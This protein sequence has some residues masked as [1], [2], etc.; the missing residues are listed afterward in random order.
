MPRSEQRL[1][2]IRDTLQERF[3]VEVELLTHVSV[4]RSQRSWNQHVSDGRVV[5]DR[6]DQWPSVRAN[7]ERARRAALK[8]V[9]L[10]AS[11]RV[12]VKWLGE[13][14]ELEDKIERA[15]RISLRILRAFATLSCDP[16]RA[17][18]LA[19]QPSIDDCAT[20]RIFV[21]R[22]AGFSAATPSDPSGRRHTIARLPRKA[23]KTLRQQ[24]PK[25]MTLKTLARVGITRSVIVYRMQREQVLKRGTPVPGVTVQLLNEGDI[26][27]YLS[28]NLIP[29]KR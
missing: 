7:P 14:Y 18:M 28:F 20:R 10:T 6:D 5:V 2:A 27:A 9:D 17:S 23:I 25:A 19:A 22:R 13:G 21:V 24:G 26:P 3:G 16:V 1:I 12:V 4:A 15:K 8:F 11:E 29:R